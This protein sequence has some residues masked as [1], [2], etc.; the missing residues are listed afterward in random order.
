M[1]IQIFDAKVSNKTPNKKKKVFIS[2]PVIKST[3]KIFDVG[4][5]I[6]SFRERLHVEAAR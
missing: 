3:Y 4:V 1:K 2:K 5:S 6:E